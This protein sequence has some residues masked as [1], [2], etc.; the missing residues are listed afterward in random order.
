MFLLPNMAYCTLFS[1]HFGLLSYCHRCTAANHKHGFSTQGVNF[2]CFVTLLWALID[3]QN[4]NL[5]TWLLTNTLLFCLK[6]KRNHSIFFLQK[7]WILPLPYP[8]GK[9]W[10]T[11]VM[12]LLLSNLAAYLS[13]VKKRSI[14]KIIFWFVTISSWNMTISFRSVLYPFR[15]DLTFAGPWGLG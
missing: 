2:G 11:L 9:S 7:R 5:V 1:T 10:P 6:T 4:Y 12:I 14:F 3:L 13:L 15:K 8:Q